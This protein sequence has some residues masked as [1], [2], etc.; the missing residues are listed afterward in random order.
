MTL[1]K[2]LALLLI[3]S[4]ACKNT[5]REKNNFNEDALKNLPQEVAID[6]FGK[7]IEPPIVVQVS[8][9]S[10]K[11]NQINKEN[12]SFAADSLT[13]EDKPFQ[14][15]ILKQDADT[16]FHCKEGTVLKI[17]QGTFVSSAE[18]N[19]VSDDITLMIK[20]YYS[21]SDI[22]LGNLSTQSGGNI[23]E[24]G[25]MIFI[26]AFN[27]DNECFIKDGK[28]IEISFPFDKHKKDM[29]LFSGNFIN[30]ILNWSKIPNDSIQPIELQAEY[31]GGY[32]SLRRFLEKK[33]E[34]PDS[35]ADIN[36]SEVALVKFFIDEAGMPVVVSIKNKIHQVF[37]DLI[38]KAFSQM[39]RWRPARRN[40]VPIKSSIHYQTITF[41]NDE[42]TT[43]DTIY[44][45][46][47]E[48]RITDTTIN[49]L[50]IAEISHYIFSVSKLG[51]INCD[52]FYNEPKPKTSLS[53][54]LKN[55]DGLDVKLVFHSFKAILHG[56]RKTNGVLF[57]DVPENETVTI[58]AIKK[59]NSNN[60]I[61]LSKSSTSDKVVKEL[62][63]EKVT[64]QGLKD[65]LKRLDNLN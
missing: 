34:I 40:G 60:Y 24:T 25:G 30:G 27:N 43:Y 48:K 35:L 63:F 7:Q 44:Q 9:F 33:I 46:E 20:E 42:K 5:D 37:N 41:F 45:R 17:E 65:K 49:D 61:S 23:L 58:V 29:M 31:P 32:N 50:T 6:T 4:V 64:L 13:I 18:T 16:I 21:I 2:L 19:P 26:Q 8:S 28:S 1:Q 22:I 12:I 39:P 55:T 47:F 15:F 3:F 57:E 51:W 11:Q 14:K 54:E 38:A 36:I 56:K 10:G 53:V 62:K 59:E 52:R